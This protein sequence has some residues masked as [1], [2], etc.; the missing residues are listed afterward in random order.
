MIREARISN[1]RRHREVVHSFEP[2]L[3]FILGSNGSGKSSLLDALQFGLFGAE[4]PKHLAQSIRFDADH[5]SVD[6]KFDELDLRRRV[7]AK[8]RTT[9]LLNGVL[10]PGQ[11]ARELVTRFGAE[12]GFLRSLVFLSEGVIY[13]PKGTDLRLSDQLEFLLPI[14]KFSETLGEVKNLLKANAAAQ[15]IERP[16]LSAS[17]TQLHQIQEKERTLTDTL[18]QMRNVEETNESLFLDAASKARQAQEWQG[19]I[20]ALRDWEA[21]TRQFCT[22]AS[23]LGI[24]GG[25]DTVVQ[26]LLDQLAQS[27]ARLEDLKGTRA[28]LVGGESVI[29][30]FLERLADPSQARCPLCMQTLTTVHREAAAREHRQRLTEFE[31]KLQALSQDLSLA[32]T[33]HATLQAMCAEATGLQSARPFLPVSEPDTSYLEALPERR[34]AVEEARQR[35][36][37]IEGQLVEIRSEVA[38]MNQ[39]LRLEER[40]VESF[41]RQA[42]LEIIASSVQDFLTTVNRGLMVPLADQLNQQ[43]KSFRPDAELSLAL[44]NSGAVSLARGSVTLPFHALSGG[45]K[46]V[47]CVLLRIAMLRAFTNSDIMIL[48]EPLEHLDPRSRRLMV[49]SLQQVVQRGM[50]KQILVSTYEESI[51]RR[52]IRRENVHAIWLDSEHGSTAEMGDD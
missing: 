5:A 37:D 52:L 40:V 33:S 1:W 43:W 45:E 41:R 24:Q 12:L 6:I 19:A 4:D 34:S 22:S 42:L 35:R 25:F 27:S 38:R 3:T 23:S 18:S 47:V 13:T 46:M 14:G 31:K 36:R 20:A 30:S 11:I 16:A 10:G 49:S 2:G 50:L 51:A 44:D 7:D 8:G 39:A 26:Q 21:K 29:R 15:R 9:E 28:E 48:D 17:R 32:E